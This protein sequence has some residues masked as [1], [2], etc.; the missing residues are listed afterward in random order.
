MM[1]QGNPCE[2]CVHWYGSYENNRCCNYIFDMEKSRPCPPGN[3]CTEY[4]P[5]R[6][7][8]DKKLRKALDRGLPLL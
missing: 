7:P 5:Y 1:Q 6:G 3:D 4:I 8:Q 2:G